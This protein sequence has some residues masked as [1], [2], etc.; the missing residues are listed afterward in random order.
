MSYDGLIVT[1]LIG[2][3]VWAVRRALLVDWPDI[4]ARF[5]RANRMIRRKDERW[6]E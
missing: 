6:F 5:K 2:V 3:Q 1:T 4:R